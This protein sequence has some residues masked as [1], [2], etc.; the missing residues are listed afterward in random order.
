MVTVTKTYNLEIKGNLFAF[1]EAEAKELFNALDSVLNGKTHPKPGEW[2]P[3][4]NFRG[5]AISECTSSD[6][7]SRVQNYIERYNRDKFKL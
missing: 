7:W 4:P 6:V 3:I 2:I 1:T 5:P